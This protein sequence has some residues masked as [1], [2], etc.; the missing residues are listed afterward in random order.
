MFNYCKDNESDLKNLKSQNR[1]NYFKLIL[2]YPT[3]VLKFSLEQQNR[4][5]N[6]FE[7]AKIIPKKESK[8]NNFTGINLSF[9]KKCFISFFQLNN[10]I[11]LFNKK[12]PNEFLSRDLV[13]I[14]KYIF[15][16]S[17]TSDQ[18]RESLLLLINNENK[19]SHKNRISDKIII[20]I[21]EIMTFYL[22]SKKPPGTNSLKTT[23][24]IKKEKEKE[25]KD[26]IDYVLNS[27]KSSLETFLNSEN[28]FIETILRILS[29]NNLSLKKE[30]INLIKIISLK[31]IE[32]L[33]NYFAKVEAEIKKSRK[34]KKINRVTG[35]EFYLFI[36]ENITPNSSND[37]IREKQKINDILNQ[38]KIEEDKERRKS[39]MDSLNLINKSID[40]KN[41]PI[42]ISNDSNSIFRNKTNESQKNK[43]KRSKTPEE[44]KI[45]D[46]K[47]QFFQKA[48]VNINIPR[49]TEFNAIDSVNRISNPVDP[50]SQQNIIRILTMKNPVNIFYE[51]E[52]EEEEDK[53]EESDL[54]ET[55]KIA[56]NLFEWLILYC[57]NDK[58][59]SVRKRSSGNIIFSSNAIYDNIDFN[60]N[61]ILINYLL[62][63]FSSKNLEVINKIL[64]LIIGQKGSNI[65]DKNMSLNKSYSRL[66][67]FFSSS[68]TKFT[69]FLEE[70]TIN[71]YLCIYH[72]EAGK[73][74]NYIKDSTYLLIEK[75]KEEYFT[76]IY[77]KAKEI[78]IDIYFYDNNL[79][80]NIINE[81]INIILHLYG[82]LKKVNEV[83]DENIKIK[84]ILFTF[85]QEFLQAIADIYNLK[86]DYY[87]K[88]LKNTN[89]NNNEK[90]DFNL[91]KYEEVKKKY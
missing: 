37:S 13:N 19:E 34:H 81:M 60:F 7:D 2:F 45:D 12:Y 8:T 90:S 3:I 91:I 40:S 28:Y 36:Q 14:I 32:T 27:P 35:K 15:L 41:K 29:T 43:D 67:G 88:I 70:L 71:S 10:F 9:C 44:K 33:N 68:R 25:K 16:V 24:S 51:D 26:K 61:E 77:K 66:L 78:I 50:N 79:N 39:S 55:Q 76:E 83:D 49:K 82:G 17:E 42:E 87:Q 59:F 72:E 58:N 74:F 53:N 65:P 80:N 1:F 57:E 73:K 5:W 11:L 86:L 22:D 62:K 75:K 85:L 64:I 18:E 56:M 23:E 47:S 54:I 46:I 89:P 52:E 30:V 4:I 6:F 20:S 31:Y 48:K 84:N 63:L 38:N 21:I 69:Q